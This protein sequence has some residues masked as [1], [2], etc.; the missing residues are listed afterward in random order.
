M[1][2]AD[3]TDDE[4]GH[5]MN[6]Y[7]SAVVFRRPSWKSNASMLPIFHAQL[8]VLSN[9]NEALSCIIDDSTEIVDH[10]G[11]LLDIGDEALLDPDR[12]DELLFDDEVFSRSRTYWWTLNMLTAMQQSLTETLAVR[13]EM[14]D[15]VIEPLVSID[16]WPLGT[17][18]V[19]R[20]D[21]IL[22]KEFMKLKDRMLQQHQRAEALRS[23][24]SKLHVS[25][26]AHTSHC[27]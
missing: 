5:G 17:E 27:H 9:S 8:Q 10:I 25:E 4:T 15:T 11:S 19:F 7:W 6:N 21:K 20:K 24:V 12:H 1:I 18:A 14:W 2:Y 23:G 26:N 13:Q 22:V 16:D 3:N